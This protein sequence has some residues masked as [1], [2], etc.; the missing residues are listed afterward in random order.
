MQGDLSARE[1]EIEDILQVTA[2]RMYAQ[3]V[4]PDWL[5]Q[6]I[7]RPAVQT[8][9]CGTRHVL[10]DLNIPPEAW[11]C[12]PASELS[13]FWIEQMHAHADVQALTSAASLVH[14][15]IKRI[16]SHVFVT[17]RRRNAWLHFLEHGAPAGVQEMPVLPSENVKAFEVPLAF[18]TRGPINCSSRYSSFIA[19]NERNSRGKVNPRAAVMPQTL[20]EAPASVAPQ[21][22]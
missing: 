17:N 14:A 20:I 16:A 1:Q 18:V 13:G 22:A 15:T 3:R 6:Y 4:V 8:V 2:R 5:R 19:F 11:S 9:L 12:I 10:E 21:E 7:S